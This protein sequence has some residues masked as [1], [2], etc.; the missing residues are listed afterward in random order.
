MP[1]CIA[2]QAQ[3]PTTVKIN[4]GVVEPQRGC[5]GGTA[6]IYIA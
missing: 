5:E 2:R 4:V 1:G 6:G 3:L